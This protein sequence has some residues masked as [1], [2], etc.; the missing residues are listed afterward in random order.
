MIA[1]ITQPTPAERVQAA[2]D[3]LQ[4]ARKELRT[5]EQGQNGPQPEPETIAAIHLSNMLETS[6]RVVRMLE[7]EMITACRRYGADARRSFPFNAE[8]DTIHDNRHGTNNPHARAIKNQLTRYTDPLTLEQAATLIHAWS[9]YRESVDTYA[10]VQKVLRTLEPRVARYMN[11]DEAEADAESAWNE[12]RATPGA[13]VELETYAWPGG[14]PLYYELEQ[15]NEVLTLCPK[16]A[17]DI[18]PG[19]RMRQQT[20]NEDPDLWCDE[21]NK[22]IE[23]AYAEDAPEEHETRLVVWYERDRIS[24]SLEDKRSQ[25]TLITIWD[26]AVHEMIGSGEL[27]TS[28]NRP[29]FRDRDLENDPKLH[30]SVYRYAQAGGLLERDYTGDRDIHAIED[31]PELEQEEASDVDADPELEQE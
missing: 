10:R 22:R 1:I 19:G 5:L 21:C 16:C 13:P 27:E 15:A 23:S 29:H 17:A 11:T 20:N 18:M 12:Y 4:A 6:A 2:Y 14:Y 8:L 26:E 28:S 3:A 9:E 30:A 7:S 31:D 24:V 25:T